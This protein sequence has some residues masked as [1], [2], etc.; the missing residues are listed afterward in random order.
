MFR[1]PHRFDLGV[2]VSCGIDLRFQPCFCTLSPSERLAGRSFSGERFFHLHAGLTFGSRLHCE[3][4]RSS[5]QPLHARKITL[6][7]PG[8]GQFL[9][10]GIPCARCARWVC[11][12]PAVTLAESKSW[13]PGVLRK[14]CT[15]SARF[16][17]CSCC[18]AI[19]TAM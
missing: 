19:F 10:P 18:G 14:R 8:L 13:L 11:G 15:S 6:K 1:R 4:A 2:A 16:E 9:V 3:R 17:P 7:S 12:H 5:Q